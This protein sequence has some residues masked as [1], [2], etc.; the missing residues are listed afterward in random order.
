MQ[1]LASDHPFTNQMRLRFE[2]NRQPCKPGRFSFDEYYD[3]FR[4]GEPVETIATAANVVHSRISAVYLAYFKRIFAD[5]SY[6]E[7]LLALRVEKMACKIPD[8]PAF[9]ILTNL[10]LRSEIVW[11]A[12]VEYTNDHW[13]YRKRQV[14]GNGHLCSLH[15][16]KGVLVCEDPLIVSARGHI[17]RAFEHDAKIIIYIIEM[18]GKLKYM[19]YIIPLDDIR[20]Y[21]TSITSGHAEINFRLDENSDRTS[22]VGHDFS[23]YLNNWEKLLPLLAVA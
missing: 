10:S 7:Y 3:H 14:Y 16:L 1:P 22:E 23:S 18:P 8:L 20:K 12:R 2:S 9:E 13:R 11:K 17:E 6:K 19:A 4:R 5:Y 15:L 21:S